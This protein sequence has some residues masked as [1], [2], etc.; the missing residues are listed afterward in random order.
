MLC[1]GLSRYTKEIRVGLYA[2]DQHPGVHQKIPLELASCLGQ[3]LV[4]RASLNMRP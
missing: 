2:C 3:G 4:L 1:K